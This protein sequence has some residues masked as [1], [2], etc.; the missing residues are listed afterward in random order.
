MVKANAFTMAFSHPM[1]HSP[2]ICHI[3][4]QSRRK[5]LRLVMFHVKQIS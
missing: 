4:A 5:G 1:T 2:V 3:P